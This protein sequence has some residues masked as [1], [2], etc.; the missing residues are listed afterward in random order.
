MGYFDYGLQTGD[1]IQKAICGGRS[2]K[3]QAGWTPLNQDVPLEEHKP[4]ES[5]AS[6]PLELVVKGVLPFRRIWTRNVIFTLAAGA[7]FDFQ[8]GSFTNIWSLFLSTPRYAPEDT[9]KTKDST[10]KRGLPMLFTGGLGMPASTVGLA[11]A[12]LGVL[13]MFLQVFLYPTVHAR[14]G[15]LRS[16]QLFFPIFAVCYFLAPYISILPSTSPAPQ[17]MS[18]PAVWL[19][20]TFVLLLQTTARTVTMPGSIIL[21][22]NSSPHPSVLGTIHGLGQSVS[23]AFR[24]VGPVVG[25]RWYGYGLDIGMVAWGWWGTAFVAVLGSLTATGMY[26]GNGHEVFLPGEHSGVR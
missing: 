25:G 9:T 17:P 11:T 24:T 10:A 5:S 3:S 18:G 12:I 4:A 23:A 26:E 20:I 2:I 21:L 16:Y 14:L 22:N 7:F 8:L 13:G 6:A 15:T 1:R 19:G